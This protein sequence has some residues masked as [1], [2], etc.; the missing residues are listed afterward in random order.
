MNCKKIADKIIEIMLKDKIILTCEKAIAV[1]KISAYLEQEILTKEYNNLK[2][3]LE[4][5]E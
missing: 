2:N 5:K 1:N 3:K 4:G